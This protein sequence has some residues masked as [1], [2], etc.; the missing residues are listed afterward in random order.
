MKP[1]V[2]GSLRGLHSTANVR[3]ADYS[4]PQ[5]AVAARADRPDVK[6]LTVVGGVPDIA[7]L[8]LRVERIVGG[9]VVGHLD[10]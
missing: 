2:S 10:L 1:T 6:E 9:E 5:R 7:K 8:V 3:I 4:H